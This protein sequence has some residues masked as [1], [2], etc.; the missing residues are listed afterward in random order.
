M[1]KTKRAMIKEVFHWIEKERLRSD[2]VK[3]LLKY[4][5]NL[6]VYNVMLV[7]YF[8]SATANEWYKYVDSRIRWTDQDRDIVEDFYENVKWIL[9]L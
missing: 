5:D 1:K 3:N 8:E 2:Q 4:Y 7:G 9:G 6:E